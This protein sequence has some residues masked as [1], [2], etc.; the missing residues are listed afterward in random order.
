MKHKNMIL[1]SVILESYKS[2]RSFCTTN[3]ISYVSVIDVINV[4]RTPYSYYGGYSK[5]AKE[6]SYALCVLPEYVFP[7][8]M[9]EYYDIECN[10]KSP[11]SSYKNNG[12]ICNGA[13]AFSNDLSDTGGISD[14][15]F[16][17]KELTSDLRAN[18][19]SDR[20]IS[21]FFRAKGIFG[22]KRNTA[23][24]AKYFNMTYEGVRQII[25]KVSAKSRSCNIINE[26][27]CIT[28]YQ[29]R[30]FI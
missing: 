9:I 11:T 25:M 10:P 21:I 20:D 22:A 28:K 12:Y 27:R 18:G 1:E 14:F 4:R 15:N 16:V 8:F 13:S 2:V 17:I 23:E 6:I 29:D 7:K 5:F 3:N 19:F 30:Y 24:I 26:I